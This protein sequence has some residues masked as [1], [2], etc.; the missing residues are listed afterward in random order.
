M[1]LLFVGSGPSCGTPVIGHVGS[2]KNCVCEEACKHHESPNRRNNVSML[3]SLYS[4][5]KSTCPPL[6]D[7]AN[8][9]ACAS[10]GGE[11]PRDGAQQ[12]ESKAVRLLIDCGKTFRAA[13]FRVMAPRGIRHVDAL[14]IT[15][16]HA[17]A[18]SSVDDF[19]EVHRPWCDEPSRIQC[20]AAPIPLCITRDALKEVKK[21]VPP[22]AILPPGTAHG[23][24]PP[25]GEHEKGC[26]VQ[27]Q[28]IL[29]PD[30]RVEPLSLTCL[31]VG[32]PFF[33]FPVE[34]GKGYYSLG[35]VWGRGT[36]LKSS[37]ASRAPDGEAGSCV[38]Y[39]SD[40][41]EITP[42]T[43]AFLQDLFVIDVLVIDLLA[44]KGTSSPAHTCWDDLWPIFRLLHPRK[45]YGVGMFCSL[46]HHHG[47][48]MWREDLE[49]EKTRI[50]DQLALSEKMADKE[51]HWLQH[52]LD[53]V[54]SIEL[55]Y[56][57]LELDL[58][59]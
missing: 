47:N 8:A 23:Q 45:T 55:A 44:E 33:S 15:H 39:I 18:M 41:S 50:R 12:S 3:I 36:V 32:Y 31:P 52:F 27:L 51:R 7:K 42:N 59:C 6:S 20:R 53:T 56:D 22:D 48:R 46:E 30:D 17:D 26:L 1:K 38:V 16:G 10:D 28:P 57:G 14:L 13:Y 4:S 37:G 58:P 35:F 34:H 54:E 5:G 21:V 2:G 29:L 11:A 9:A 24:V 49:V 43:M 19:R 25:S 40:V